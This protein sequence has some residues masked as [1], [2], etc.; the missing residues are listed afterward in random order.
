MICEYY[1]K[2]ESRVTNRQKKTLFVI[3]H[4]KDRRLQLIEAILSCLNRASSRHLEQLSIGGGELFISRVTHRERVNALFR[5]RKLSWGLSTEINND[6]LPP[7]RSTKHRERE[8]EGDRDTEKNGW[9]GLAGWR[10]LALDIEWNDVTIS[11]RCNAEKK[12]EGGKKV[13]WN[14]GKI[15]RPLIPKGTC[16]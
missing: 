8:R 11:A 16:I 10:W 1:W 6:S 9:H 14:E 13:A 7:T 15:N 3:L 2:N 5:A 4:E 12:R